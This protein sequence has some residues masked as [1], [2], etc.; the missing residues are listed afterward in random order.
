[1][2]SAR[3]S[4]LIVFSIDAP[5]NIAHGFHHI[6]GVLTNL[7]PSKEVASE[8]LSYQVCFEL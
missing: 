6:V 2:R 5:N 1:M 3:L 8:V 4:K 7:M